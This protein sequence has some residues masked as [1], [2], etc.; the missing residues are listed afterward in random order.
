M[1]RRARRGTLFFVPF[2]PMT[3]GWCM[4]G[5]RFPDV[6]HLAPPWKKLAGWMMTCLL[7]RNGTQR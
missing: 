1:W 7:I 2:Q 3:I 6:L 5:R 4:L